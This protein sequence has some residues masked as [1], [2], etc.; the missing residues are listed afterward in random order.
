MKNLDSISAFFIILSFF[1][2]G[3]GTRA[4]TSPTPTPTVLPPTVTTSATA[5]NTI[6]IAS[7]EWSPYISEHMPHYGIWS[8]IVT[9]AFAIQGITVEYGFFPWNR[10]LNYVSSGLWDGSLGWVKTPERDLFA[11]FPT[12]PIANVED[13]CFVF[14]HRTDYEFDWE[15]V[16]DLS[17]QHIGT[18]LGYAQTE[19]LIAARDSGIPLTLDIYGEE[20]T[21]LK[22][23]LANRFN[24]LVCAANICTELLK[25]NFTPEEVALVTY[26]PTPWD[27]PEYHLMISKKSPR[28]EEWIQIFEQ[29]LQQLKDN[30][31]Y[32][33]LLQDFQD[34]TYNVQ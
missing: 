11:L 5:N 6:R 15:T 10:S 3:C 22:M 8:H 30:G 7:G 26:H 17:G 16:E 27:C 34:G 1:I 19:Q 2:V 13:M 18:M 23:L 14:F 28:A 9:E 31:R 25:E 24:L 12:T 20:L 33:Q 21:N 32:N 4:T 29:G